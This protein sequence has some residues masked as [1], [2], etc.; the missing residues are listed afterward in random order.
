MY[1]LFSALIL[2]LVIGALVDIIARDDG[3]V[4]HLPKMAWVL[5]VVFLPLVGSI[6]WFLVG[7]EWSRPQPAVPFG[8][9]RRAEARRPDSA[10]APGST[11][12]QLA[13]L[14][15]EIAAT[16]REER[17]RRLEAELEAKRRRTAGE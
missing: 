11:E 12:A 10:P 17:I 3:Q 16:E 1:L 4:R 7:R 2:L 5:L 8:D 13:A 14:E 15:A 6:V 9:P